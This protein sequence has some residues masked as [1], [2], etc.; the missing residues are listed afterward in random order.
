[1]KSNLTDKEIA[2]ILS[3]H[4]VGIFPNFQDYRLKTILKNEILNKVIEKIV[5]SLVLG[6]GIY[7]V[8]NLLIVEYN[9]I[10]ISGQNGLSFR[11][12]R[13]ILIQVCE[14]ISDSDCST[15]VGNLKDKIL[16]S[17]LDI[18]EIRTFIEVKVY[19]KI[20]DSV[21]AE[22][23][24]EVITKPKIAKLIKMKLRI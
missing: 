18:S 17:P 16:T 6:F 20:V 9:P 14:I 19:S 10:F 7:A 24:Q 8:Y 1:M 5:N 3:N 22:N 21:Q 2:R 15:V 23:I 12:E 11:S 13:G 4:R